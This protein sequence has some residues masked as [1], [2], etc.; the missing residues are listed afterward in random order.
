MLRALTFALLLALPAAAVEQFPYSAVGVEVRADTG[1]ALGRIAAV[2]R[3]AAGEIVAAEIPGLEPPDAPVP[4]E[5]FIAQGPE[6][7]TPALRSVDLSAQACA[8]AS[9]EADRCRRA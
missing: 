2:E 4:P 6:L 8:R 3:N 9:A 7:R 5:S 1:V